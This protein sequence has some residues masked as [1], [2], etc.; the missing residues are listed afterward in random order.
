MAGPDRQE[1]VIIDSHYL[2]EGFDPISSYQLVKEGRDFA[3]IWANIEPFLI[4]LLV[5]RDLIRGTQ[6]SEYLL[7]FDIPVGFSPCLML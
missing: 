2:T 3:R 1:I 4:S 6:N 5:S 7:I